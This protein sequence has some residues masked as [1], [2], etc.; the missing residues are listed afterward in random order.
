MDRPLF[1]LLGGVPENF[2][3][4]GRGP[5]ECGLTSMPTLFGSVVMLVELSIKVWEPRP[6]SHKSMGPRDQHDRRGQ[7]GE[8]VN[9]L[10]GARKLPAQ[11]KFSEGG[12]DRLTDIWLKPTQ[13]WAWPMSEESFRCQS[14]RHKINVGPGLKTTH[15]DYK[16]RG[17][18]LLSTHITTGTKR[19]DG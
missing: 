15:T 3:G 7:R 14:E 5:R 2:A 8:E 4:A 16:G 6:G 13:C 18:F 1:P 11:R 12:H 17:L 9:S 19:D 10:F